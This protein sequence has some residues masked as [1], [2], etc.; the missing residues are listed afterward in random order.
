MKIL[1]NILVVKT[2]LVSFEFKTDGWVPGPNDSNVT[3][4]IFENWTNLLPRMLR[5]HISEGVEKTVTNK[6]KVAKEW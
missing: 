1:T 5:P 2:K 4:T 6:S 3:D